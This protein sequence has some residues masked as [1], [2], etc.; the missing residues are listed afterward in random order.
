[1][2][3]S[4]GVESANTEASATFDLQPV[5]SDLTPS[6]ADTSRARMRTIAGAMKIAGNR[7]AVRIR[8]MSSKMKPMLRIT[9]PPVAVISITH[10]VSRVTPPSAA[11]KRI[12]SRQSTPLEAEHCSCRQDHTHAERG[13]Q[14]HRR[15]A[16]QCGFDRQQRIIGHQPVLDG[17]EDRQRPTQKT[18]ARC[19]RSPPAIVALPAAPSPSRPSSRTSNQRPKRSSVSSI[20]NPSPM[21]PP[22]STLEERDEDVCGL[23][24]HRDAQDDGNQAQAE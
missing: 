7:F 9:M 10:G 17:A 13:C 3:S 21:I 5:T 8:L 1:M 16:V 20:R 24:C 23:R 22:I 11:P 4:C 12:A 14:R 2:A 19:R 15:E 6:N 18:Q